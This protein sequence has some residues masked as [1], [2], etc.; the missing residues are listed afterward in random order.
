MADEQTLQSVASKY[1]GSSVNTPAGEAQQRQASPSPDAPT[2]GDP[3]IRSQ[4]APAPATDKVVNE[5]NMDALSS[6]AARYSG[7]DVESM[8]EAYQNNVADAG[9]VALERQPRPTRDQ[10]DEYGVLDWFG[11]VGR[12]T[13]LGPLADPIAALVLTQTHDVSYRRAMDAIESQREAKGGTSTTAS[14]AGAFLG[15]GVVAAGLKKGATYAATRSGLARGA[16][17]WAGKDK[18]L[19]RVVAAAA[20]GAAAGAVEEGIRTSLEETIDATQGQGFDTQRVTDSVLLGALIGGAATPALQEGLNGA[21]WMGTFLKRTLGNDDATT[22]QA[23][24]M[25]VRALAKQGEDMDTTVNRWQQKVQEFRMRTGRTPAAAEIMRPEEVASVSEVIRS[26]SGLDIVAKE[27]GE[28]GVRRA[29]KDYDDI[30]RRGGDV[31][32][33]E[34]IRVGMEDLFTDVMNRHGK[35]PVQVPDE[36]IGYL[37]RNRD[38]L[39]QIAQNGN[40]GAAKMVRVLDGQADIDKITRNYQNAVSTQSNADA[41]RYVNQL[42]V[43]LEDLVQREMASGG[44]ELSERQ[45][46]QNLV[47][48]QQ[49]LAN[50]Q[51]SGSQLNAATFRVSEMRGMLDEAN[52]VLEAY[53]RD[54]LQISLSDANA[55]RATA[56]K[57]SFQLRNAD[58][59]KADQARFVRDTVARVGTEVDEYSDVVKRFN[60]ENTRADAQAMGALA[61]KGDINAMELG[62]RLERGRLQNRPKARSGEQVAAVRQGAAEGTQRSLQDEMRGTPKTQLAAAERMATSPAAQGTVAQTLGDATSKEMTRAAQQVLDTYESMKKLAAPVSE[63]VMASERKLAA[64]VMTGA[65]FGSLGGAGRA[66]LLNRLL[67]RSQIP[68]G[69]AKKIVDMLGDPSQIDKALEFVQSKGIRVGPMFAAVLAHLSEPV[70]NDE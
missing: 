17:Q 4:A 23:T 35:T 41:F 22:Y 67:T 16:M 49:K 66:A 39:R 50:L 47:N 62:T 9:R 56:S 18:V 13:I 64:D 70:S 44:T 38:F 8:E 3:A 34:T 54:G 57:K 24:S 40:D 46:L 29:L 65:V 32:D 27:Y 48:M 26:F 51:Q 11:D 7:Y 69:T 55:I 12:G 42:K 1:S 5:Q 53:R 58:P 61:S 6:V 33:P 25:V 60:L 19:N 30:I 14:I 37:M 43:D 63:T 31:P 2:S 59:D 15:G 28:Q 36:T 20:T 10:E 45:A 21:K 52:K 68:S